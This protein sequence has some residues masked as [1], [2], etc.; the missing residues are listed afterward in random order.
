MATTAQIDANQSNAQRSTGPASQAGKQAS[1]QNRT[2]H[3]L[4]HTNT[5]FY[6][7]PDEDRE[8]FAE[9]NARLRQEHQ[10]QTE[11]ELILVRRLGE[12]E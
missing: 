11:T 2:T 7:L 12:H 5:F 8:K 1:S 10:P 3:G 6:L 4:C 9:L